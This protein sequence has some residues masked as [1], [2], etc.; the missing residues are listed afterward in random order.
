MRRDRRRVEFG[1]WQ[2]PLTLAEE[3]LGLVAE[4]GINPASVLEP[5]CGQGAFLRAASARF[6]DVRLFGLEINPAHVEAARTALAATSAELQVAD[7]FEIEWD[8]FLGRLPEPLL[9]VGNPPWVTNSELGVLGSDN[10]P[11]KLNFKGL[12]GLEAMT[13]K[14]NF[15]V[16]EWM[17]L[18]LL[19]A[20]QGR[21]FTLAMLCKASVARRIMEYGTARQWEFAGATYAI[22]ARRHFQAAVDAVLMVVKPGARREVGAQAEWR[23]HTSLRS[24]EP[25]R[26]MGVIQ[27]RTYSDLARYAR[28]RD[29]EGSSRWE[30][31][32]GLKHDCARVMELRREGSGFV[33]GF[34]ERLA[35]EFEYVFPLLKGADLANGRLTEERFVLVTQ[36][37]LGE[38][39]AVIR[40][41]A[42][43]TWSYLE[44]HRKHLEARKSSIYRG[45]PAF[46]VFGVGAYAFAPFKVA[47]CGLYKRL[48]FRL[49]EPREGMPVMLD[50]TCYFVPCQTREEAAAL[51]RGLGSREARDFFEAR[52]FWDAK[53]PISKALLQAL[54]LDALI[55]EEEGTVLHSCVP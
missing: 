45:Q 29:L 43:R 32:S 31:R 19:S 6:P 48:E 14:S 4:G 3:I 2:T 17:I 23:V 12:S 42:P 30:W 52:V 54:S 46:A 50:D 9:V 41:R 49:I 13:G 26:R 34:G 51:V 39:T 27:G 44:R 11:A 36:R 22:D 37:A 40:Q 8:S 55:R 25:T 47:I 1:D 20:L 21:R 16:S 5:T 24:R 7:F 38:D 53:R 35:L 15:D 33:N 10:L 18:R 28:T